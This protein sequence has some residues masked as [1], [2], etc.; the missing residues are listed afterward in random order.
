MEVPWWHMSSS[1]EAAFKYALKHNSRSMLISRTGMPDEPILC[2][3][4]S[5]TKAETTMEETV[6]YG[7]EYVIAASD[8]PPTYVQPKR[9]DTLVDAE[10]GYFTIEQ[11]KEMIVFGKI[12]GYRV[13]TN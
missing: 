8:V 11:V 1:I 4:A 10:M 5:F 13:R 6:V 7:R 2:G 12:I 9:G 3:V